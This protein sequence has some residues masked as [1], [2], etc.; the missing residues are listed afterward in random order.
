MSILERH[1]IFGLLRSVNCCRTANFDLN[2]V[3]ARLEDA[4]NI[5]RVS[6]KRVGSGE[7]EFVIEE[8]FGMGVDSVESELMKRIVENIIA[9]GEVF[10]VAEI[11]F[12]HPFH[13]RIVA[14][15]QRVVDCSCFL[16]I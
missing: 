13:L 14:L 16:Q 3:S 11:T 2:C 6:S 4:L 10:R 15:Q 12:G 5:R 7:D 8:H 9:N 1:L